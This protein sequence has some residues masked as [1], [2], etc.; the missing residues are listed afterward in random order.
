MTQ[1]FDETRE[2]LGHG[3][4]RRRPKPG[5]VDSADLK[6]IWIYECVLR[7]STQVTSEMA[8]QGR[9]QQY[10]RDTFADAIR[11]AADRLQYGDGRSTPQGVG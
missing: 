11:E 8:P 10:V 2:D 6:A 1:S 5:E 3:L 4:T 7:M 9:A